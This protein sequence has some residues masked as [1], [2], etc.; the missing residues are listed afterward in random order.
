[1]RGT[2]VQS[3]PTT[4][5]TFVVTSSVVTLPGEPRSVAFR[6]G[7]GSA[8]L[9]VHL[10]GGMITQVSQ[11]TDTKV[12]ETINAVA[13]LA[14]TVADLKAAEPPCQDKASVAL[15]PIVDGKPRRQPAVSF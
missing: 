2:G 6:S 13:G 8:N 4:R 14:K 10:S 5:W 15:Y 12:P 3:D 1:M 11:N 9:G 7:Y